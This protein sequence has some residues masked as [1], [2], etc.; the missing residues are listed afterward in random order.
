[1]KGMLCIEIMRKNLIE[2]KF[3]IKVFIYLEKEGAE[4]LIIFDKALEEKLFVF[5]IFEKKSQITITITN[6]QQHWIKG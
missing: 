3:F 2:G 5:I 4:S 1:M 6:E